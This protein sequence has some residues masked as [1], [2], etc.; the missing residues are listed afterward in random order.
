[1]NEAFT[2][3]LVTV[4]LGLYPREWRNRYGGEIRELILV[5]RQEHRRSLVR[6]VPSLIAGATMERFYALRR[7]DRSGITAAILVT[8]VAVGAIVTFS[9]RIDVPRVHP[10][11]PVAVAHG[12]ALGQTI[13]LPA[14]P[15]SR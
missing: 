3:L 14:S 2:E 7:L 13:D 8:V 4:V 9:H 15:R 1:M 11:A 6:M 12:F 10:A 5:L